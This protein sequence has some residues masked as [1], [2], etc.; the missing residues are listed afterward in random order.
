[1]SFP[2]PPAISPSSPV[3]WEM[4][5]DLMESQA[6]AEQPDTAAAYSQRVFAA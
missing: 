1:M 4:L 6:E 2:V 3:T 5:Q